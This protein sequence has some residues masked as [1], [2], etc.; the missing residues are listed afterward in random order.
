MKMTITKRTILSWGLLV[1][2]MIPMILDGL[3]FVIYHHHEEEDCVGLYFQ[4]PE[5]SHILCSY[6]FVTK[7]L[8]NNK[9][10]IYPFERLIEFFLTAETHLAETVN[11]FPN[12]LRGP[13]SKT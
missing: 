4:A 10:S 3:H 8:D 5:E 11:Y 12:P 6:P 7:E 9:L 13:P 1:S 2:L